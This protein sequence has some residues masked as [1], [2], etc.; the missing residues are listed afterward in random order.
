MKA[1]PSWNTGSP[2]PPLAPET[3]AVWR[4]DIDAEIEDVAR[5]FA[6]LSSAERELSR[7]LQQPRKRDCFIATRSILR[8]LLSHYSGI[9]A[10]R[11]RI[12]RNP[13]GKPFVDGIEFNISHSR[14][15][16]LMAF[17]RTNQVGIDVQYMK[18]ALD[19]AR[20]AQR[21]YTESEREQIFAHAD[22]AAQRDAFFAIWTRKEAY[23]KAH[24]TSFHDKLSSLDL[25]EGRDRFDDTELGGSWELKTFKLA[26]EYWAS[27]CGQDSIGQICNYI[28]SIE[29]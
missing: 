17:S 12:E 29:A 1:Y 5:H 18:P 13:H 23:V 6:Q 25:P 20:I 28:W 21:R 4:I 10:K 19:F 26:P 14:A 3:T 15:W 22:V 8:S 27:V 11:L 24:G 2:P 9:P 7:R 16:A